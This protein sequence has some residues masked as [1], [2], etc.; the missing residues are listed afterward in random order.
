MNGFRGR[1]PSASFLSVTRCPAQSSEK[2]PQSRKAAQVLALAVTRR[3]HARAIPWPTPG[4]ADE[5]GRAG[6]QD[7][8]LA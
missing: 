7:P 8:T 5:R 3:L 2:P 1:R 4:N 6:D